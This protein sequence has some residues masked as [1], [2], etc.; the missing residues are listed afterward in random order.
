M[1][2]NRTMDKFQNGI[3][4]NF[5][6]K[7]QKQNP[8]ALAVNTVLAG[9]YLV[10]PVLGEGG[11]GIT[12][13]GY[14]LNMETRIAIKEYFPVELVTRDTTRRSAGDSGSVS[15][16]SIPSAKGAFVSGNLASASEPSAGGVSSSGGGSDRVISLS[17]EKSKT[18]QQGLKKYVDEARN[19]SQFADI[20]GI[21]SVKDFFYENNTAYI[22]MEYIEGISLKE[23]LKQKGGKLSEEESLAILR[24]VLE[25]LEKVHAAGIVHRDISPDNIMLTFAEEGE[26]ETGQSGVVAVYGNISAVK[27]IDFGAARMTSKNDQKS[28]TVILKHGY[29]P[30]EQYRSHGEQGPWTDVYAICAVLYRMLTGK[31]PEPAMDRLFSDGLK[32]PEELGVKIT[33]AVSEAILRGLAV[34]KEDR[35]QSVRELVDA[36]DGKRSKEAK[37]KRKIWG[38]MAAIAGAIG[39]LAVSGLGLGNLGRGEMGK[40]ID[41]PEKDMTV[42]DTEG[43]DTGSMA[44]EENQV[45]EGKSAEENLILLEEEEEEAIAFRD[46]QTVIAEDGSVILLCLPDGSVKAYGDNEEGQCEVENWGDVVAV[47]A[48]VTQSLGL[49]AN[50]T[51]YAAGKNTRGECNVGTWKDIVAV[52]AGFYASFGLCADGTVVA[53]G[54]TERYDSEIGSWSNIKAI[55]AT[56]G[57]EYG[58]AA[59]DTEGKVFCAGFDQELSEVT[60][61]EDVEHIQLDMIGSML[62]LVGLREDGTI[63]C[64]NLTEGAEL[65]E[66]DEEYLQWYEQLETWSDMEQISPKAPACGVKKDGTI[67]FS[68]DGLIFG[69][70]MQE[71]SR[72]KLAGWDNMEAVTAT[73]GSGGVLVTGITRDGQIREFRENSGNTELED[74]KN[75]KWVKVLNGGDGSIIAGTQ[76]G[77]ILTYGSDNFMD[78]MMTMLPQDGAEK[79]I[80]MEGRAVLLAEDGSAYGAGYLG[81]WKEENVKQAVELWNYAVYDT[82][83]YALLLEDGSVKILSVGPGDPALEGTAFTYEGQFEEIKRKAESWTQ[84]KQLAWNEDFLYGLREDGTVV[85]TSDKELSFTEARQEI[86]TFI[87]KERALIALTEVGVIRFLISNADMETSG[88][89][90]AERWEN[91]TDFALGGNHVVGLLADGTVTAAGRNYAGQCDVEDWEDIVYVTAGTC[92]TIGITTDGELKIAGFLY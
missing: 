53:C 27:L 6:V 66:Y 84:V 17:G 13:A 60:G 91:V 89:E 32:R 25:A 1:E 43:Q 50:G 72:L 63:V 86:R 24:P 38:I 4:E 55:S 70:H 47:S 85:S 45:E 33:P 34:K 57:N 76:E 11:F 73:Y 14:D 80:G 78:Y 15:G 41:I 88:M 36:L 26:A 58:L 64:H 42:L 68:E 2:G 83:A 28:L 81:Q 7:P 19:V 46:P 35:I 87:G 9:K 20:P 37:T 12:Y 16:G 69:Y 51:V 30:E 90:A 65:Q 49:D 79:W 52:E 29:A 77:Q 82:A 10:G 71:E 8:R 3:W 5:G 23:Y 54:D 22:V 92:C 59:L 31:V 62:M 75:L 39:I 44:A 61:W 74:M 56:P 18:Y 40:N 21:V 67:V 48:N